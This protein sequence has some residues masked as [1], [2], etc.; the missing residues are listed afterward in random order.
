M[1]SNTWTDG[2][3]DSMRK[4]GDPLA[5]GTAEAIFRNKDI[6]GANALF[7]WLVSEDGV[8]EARGI[9]ELENY[10]EQSSRLPEWADEN[11]IRQ[12]E[13]VFYRWGAE[14]ITIL[15]ASS[16]PECYV[17]R[18][19]AKVL[20]ETQRLEAHVER[21]ARETAQMVLDVMDRGGLLGPGERRGILAAQKVRLM[22]ATVRHLILGDPEPSQDPSLASHLGA[23]D[24]D[25]EKDGHPI[26]QE[27]LA[28]VLMTFSHVILRGWEDLGIHLKDDEKAAYVHSWNVVGHVMGVSKGLLPLEGPQAAA[29]LFDTIKARQKA[30]TPDGAKLTRSLR[31]LMERMNPPPKVLTRRLPRILMRELLDPETCALLD[32]PKLGLFDRAARAALLSVVRA[33][34]LV[35]HEAYH[36]IAGTGRLAGWLSEGILKRLLAV[37]RMGNRQ[38]YRLPDRLTPD[39]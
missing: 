24:W 33:F 10:L 26:N 28:L 27:D 16:L 17:M 14:A 37:P 8:P 29:E 3:L 7:G 35:R 6:G 2:F 13:D 1:A 30:R 36:D 39:A 23:L 5:D 25:E 34:S 22:H 11:L 21:R 18:S 20:G 12:G 32:V 9:P 38:P 4:K 31:L 19:I 15:A